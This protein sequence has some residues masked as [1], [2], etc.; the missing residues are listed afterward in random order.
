MPLEINRDSIFRAFKYIVYGFLALNV[1]LFFAEEWAASAH[2]FA[3]GVAIK[4]IIEGFAASI[5]TAAWVVLLL[6]FEF[7]TYV[8]DEE[9]FT[10]RTTWNNRPKPVFQAAPRRPSLQSP[11]AP[12]SRGARARTRQPVRPATGRS[13]QTG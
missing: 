11:A 3:D 7:E 5:D 12:G 1:Y 10:K 2:R 8:L 4:D 6:M 13:W 9:Q